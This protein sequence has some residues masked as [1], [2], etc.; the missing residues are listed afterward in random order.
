MFGLTGAWRQRV[1]GPT[2]QFTEGFLEA[3]CF[4]SSAEIISITGRMVV[5]LLQAKSM[6][7]SG[8]QPW[9]GKNHWESVRASRMQCGVVGMPHGEVGENEVNADASLRD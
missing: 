3:L 5:R 4:L 1:S 2:E 7:N 9:H 8:K 6:S